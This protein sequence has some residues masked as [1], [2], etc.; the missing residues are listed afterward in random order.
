MNDE[1][2]TWQPVP[3]P[4]MTPEE[5]GWIRSHLIAYGWD[6]AM[7]HITVDELGNLIDGYKRS[8]IAWGLGISNVPAYVIQGAERYP[9]EAERAA[10]YAELRRAINDRTTLTDEIEAW[11]KEARRG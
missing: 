9:D 4:A 3:Y 7:G 5:R 11:L 8:E 6:D 1:K 2:W 10:K